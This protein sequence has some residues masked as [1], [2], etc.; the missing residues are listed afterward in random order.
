MATNQENQ[1][2]SKAQQQVVRMV[3]NPD[4]VYCPPM[5]PYL[6][7][8][9]KDNDIVVLN[10]QSG[11]LTVSGRLPAHKDCLQSRVNKVLPTA[12]VVHRLDREN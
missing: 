4:F 12:T 1:K 7:I 2:D 10:K 6:N 11:L 3:P 8:I 9:Y 5:S